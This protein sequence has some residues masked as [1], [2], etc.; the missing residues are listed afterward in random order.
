MFH[1]SNFGKWQLPCD[2]NGYVGEKGDSYEDFTFDEMGSGPMTPEQFEQWI[3]ECVEQTKE[4]QLSLAQW[5][6]DGG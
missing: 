1:K 5:R 6:N 3:E 2:I 4:A